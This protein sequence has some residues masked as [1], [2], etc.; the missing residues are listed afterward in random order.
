MKDWI[1]RTEHDR[2]AT[3]ALEWERAR[4]TALEKGDIETAE[5][6][7]Q[8][9]EGWLWHLYWYDNTRPLLEQKQP[10][11]VISDD[12]A[13]AIGDAEALARVRRSLEPRAN[14]SAF[15][16]YSGGLPTLGEHR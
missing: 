11:R 10:K 3:R 6:A 4:K 1:S 15:R 16:P 12:E 8:H 2:I 14:A 7:K 5:L 9:G 13:E